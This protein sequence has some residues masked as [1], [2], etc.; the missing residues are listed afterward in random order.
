MNKA[1]EKLYSE[2][3]DELS[4]RAEKLGSGEYLDLLEAFGSHIQRCIDCVKDETAEE[5]GD[6]P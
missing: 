1:T 5:T 2:L 3:Q 6:K 4:K